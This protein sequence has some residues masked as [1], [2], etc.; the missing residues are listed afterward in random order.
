MKEFESWPE[1]KALVLDN[2]NSICANAQSQDRY[3]DEHSA[4]EQSPSSDCAHSRSPPNGRRVSGSR[5]AEGEE[6]VRCT[7]VLGGLPID[8]FTI[9][10]SYDENLELGISNRVHNPIPADPNP[11][12]IAL[13]RQLL[14][15]DRARL[16]GELQNARHNALP[17]FLLVNGLDLLGRGRLDQD[18][19]TCHDV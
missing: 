14:T 9:C 5:R 11:I 17:V 4:E 3:C 1:S 12:A 15:P 13:S 18:P 16:L 2:T 6:R 8:V 7:R 19:I 10:D